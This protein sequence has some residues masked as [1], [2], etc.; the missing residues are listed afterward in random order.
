MFIKLDETNLRTAA[1]IHSKA[2]KESHKTFCSK[3]FVELHTV[4]RQTEYLRNEM[5]QGKDLYLLVHDHP[6]GIVSI[7]DNLI[8]HLYVLPEAQHQG[9]G[10]ELLQFAIQRCSGIPTLW[11]LSGNQRALQLYEAHGFCRTG[12]EHPLSAGLFELE[13]RLAPDKKR[14]LPVSEAFVLSAPQG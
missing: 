13:L 4:E 12:S 11:V 8:E 6:V 3:A 5:R 2:W 7:R 14:D 10:T 1:E 9:Y